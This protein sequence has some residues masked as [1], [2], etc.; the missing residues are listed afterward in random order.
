MLKEY[1]NEIVDKIEENV[2]INKEIYELLDTLQEDIDNKEKST[3]ENEET[4]ENENENL[5]ITIEDEEETEEDE[6]ETELTNDNEIYE[7]LEEQN[8]EII[9]LL[10]KNNELQAEN[11]LVLIIA[12]AI[13]FSFYYL[14]N[15]FSK[16]WFFD[17]LH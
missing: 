17:W 5:M 16:W 7:I 11:S 14:I 3:I 1:K 8:N 10:E 2:S 6:E 12:L 13:S 4:E 9:E 15:Q